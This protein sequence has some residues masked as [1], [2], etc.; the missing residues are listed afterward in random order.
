MSNLINRD[1]HYHTQSIGIQKTKVF[2]LL[3]W[4]ISVAFP[5]FPADSLLKAEFDSV[6]L[7]LS[8]VMTLNENELKMRKFSCGKFPFPDVAYMKIYYSVVSF[9][10]VETSTLQKQHENWLNCEEQQLQKIHQR[11]SAT[12]MNFL[13]WKWNEKKRIK[14]I[15]IE[16]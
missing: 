15:A 6:S 11:S 2:L 12:A 8:W 13:G 1:F 9:R 7:F 4:I 14:W 10:S 3:P 5:F 16:I